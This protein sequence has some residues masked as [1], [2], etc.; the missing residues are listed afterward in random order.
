MSTGPTGRV[1][2]AP[3]HARAVLGARRKGAS[4]RAAAAAG[5]P[6]VLP[7]R[8]VVHPGAAVDA[9]R[10]ADLALATGVPLGRD[11][12]VTGPHLLAF[13]AQ[14]ELLAAADFPL[15]LPGL[16]HVTQRVRQH[17]P[18]AVGERVE[19]RVSARGP[20]PHPKGVVVELDAVLTTGD[21]VVW[22]GTSGYLARGAAAQ[23]VPRDVDGAPLPLPGAPERVVARWQVPTTTGRSYAAASGDVN[24]IHVSSLA[25]RGFGFRGAVAHGMWTLARAVGQVAPQLG[26]AVEV[27]ARFGSPLLLGSR[28]ALC[29]EPV[30]AGGTAGAEGG[31]WALAVRSG[32]PLPGERLHLTAEAAPLRS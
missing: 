4:V 32:T 25:A 12:P 30:G 24:P 14:L 28:A 21:E 5:R 3:V 29:A 31:S 6:L 15:P 13:A 10:A 2:L 19:V 20:L 23:E 26:G 8:A 17:R 11:L 9:G 1:S 27:R 22:E 7:V 18:L 16:V